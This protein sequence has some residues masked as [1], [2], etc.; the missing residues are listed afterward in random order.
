MG[1]ERHILKMKNWKLSQ[2]LNNS[3]WKAIIDIFVLT[4][5]FII[6]FSEHHT[7]KRNSFN[8]NKLFDFREYAVDET[9]IL[10]FVP[11]PNFDSS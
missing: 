8:E 4:I 9:P 1:L 2:I 5:L 11:F 10:N 3:K 7:Q 6:D